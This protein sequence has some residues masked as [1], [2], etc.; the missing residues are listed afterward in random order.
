MSI[1]IAVP[2]GV[3]QRA[4][5]V[6]ARA[7]EN[8]LV[9]VE[10]PP[11]D[12]NTLAQFI[13]EQQI[14]HAILGGERFSGPLYAAM[15]PGG[16]LARFGV[17]YDGLD[18]A[19]AT[20]RGLYCTITPGT[21]HVSVAEHAMSLLL[22]GARQLTHLHTQTREGHWQGVLATEVRGKTLA[23]IGCGAIGSTLAGIASRG[24]GMRVLGVEVRDMDVAAYCHEHGYSAIVR[25]WEDAV[26][27]ADF[28]S[29]H[30]PA[31]PATRAMVN[32]ERIAQM[33]P[34]AWLINTARGA[35][36]DEQALYDALSEG[37]IAGAALD[38]FEREPYQPTHLDKDL[39]TLPNV[40]MTP[41]VASATRDACA[42]MAARAL[43]NILLAERGAH[44]EMD[45]VN[46]E[47]LAR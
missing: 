47:V 7:T 35:I 4:P 45:L 43:Q 5:E 12:E 38:V 33:L 37:R 10:M 21:L 9:C 23:I 42:R 1:R 44:H 26:P 40:I 41:H 22:A 30:V 24:F 8:G 25:A 20:A 17:G 31:T 27:E 19:Q 11:G 46:P 6:F 34:T 39:R 28:V 13:R 32:A 3:M 18:L 15:E 16:V 29:L 14:R 36:V 2:R